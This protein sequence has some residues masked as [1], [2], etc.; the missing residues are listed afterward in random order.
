MAF[1]LVIGDPKT[2]KCIQKEISEENAKLFYGKKIGDV[3][4]GEIID[5]TGYEFEITGGS[6]NAG[7]PMR[8]DLPGTLTKKIFLAKGVGYRSLGKGIKKKKRVAG[9]TIFEKTAQVNVK[10]VKYGS[11]PL[12]EEKKE[13]KPSEEKK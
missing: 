2:K 13:E 1:K 6:N 10:V 4:K 12:F 8:K 11:K 9:N 3:I 7:F 5:L